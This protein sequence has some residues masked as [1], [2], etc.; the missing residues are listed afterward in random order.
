MVDNNWHGLVQNKRNE[1]IVLRFDEIEFK[2]Q[3]ICSCCIFFYLNVIN[4]VFMHSISNVA[5]LISHKQWCGVD[6]ADK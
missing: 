2:E 6:F 4:F 5:T 3:I 1:H